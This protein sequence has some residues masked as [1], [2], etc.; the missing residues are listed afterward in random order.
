[1]SARK[2][3]IESKAQEANGA[4]PV[5]PALARA[6]SLHLEGKHKD[7]LRELNTA[8]ENGEESAEI[9]SAKGHLQFELEQFE[10]AVEEII[11]AA[12]K[13]IKWLEAY[14]VQFDSDLLPGCAPEK[15]YPIGHRDLFRTLRGLNGTVSGVVLSPCQITELQALLAEACHRVIDGGWFR[16]GC[17]CQTAM[18]DAES[19]DCQRCL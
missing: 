5:S 14:G 17:D 8:I 4:P 15:S 11:Q 7:A 1:M 10:E 9:Y 6:V 2:S 19:H 16:I 13:S 18:H 3:P 12:P